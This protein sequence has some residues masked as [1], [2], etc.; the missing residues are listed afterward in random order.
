[1]GIEIDKTHFAER[2]Y[3]AFGA[4]L[5]ENLAA[6]QALLADPDFGRGPHSLGAE[7]EMYLVDAQGNP[8]SA[9]REVLEAA[10]DKQLTLE[11]NRYNLE[12]NLSPYPLSES[13][14]AATETEILTKLEQLRA[15]ASGL[16][17]RVVPIGILPTLRQSDFGAHCI[18]RP[19]ALPRSGATT[20]TTP[21]R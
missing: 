1:M 16:G 15:V 12:Y 10:D 18:Y 19:Q 21:R 5:E 14:F 17:G 3:L 20:D 6:L 8:L 2:D 11:L 13:P 9:N 4:R 7:L